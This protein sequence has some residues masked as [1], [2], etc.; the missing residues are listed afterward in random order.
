MEKEQF[1]N[2]V[3]EKLVLELDYRHVLAVQPDYTKVE[4][5]GIWYVY[6]RLQ[7]VKMS[8]LEFMRKKKLKKN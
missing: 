1:M 3:K 8:L 5:N 6:P 4:G 2:A 7:P